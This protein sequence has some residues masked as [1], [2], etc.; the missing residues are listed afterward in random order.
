MYKAKVD[1]RSESWKRR[2]I[3][4]NKKQEQKAKQNIWECWRMKWYEEKR[5]E[6]EEVKEKVRLYRRKNEWLRCW[7]KSEWLRR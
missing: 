5:K 1:I 6:K 3:K 2:Q 4:K 7:A